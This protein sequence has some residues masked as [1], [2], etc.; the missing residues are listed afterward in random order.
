MELHVLSPDVISRIAAGE[1]VERPASVVKELV[2]NSVD[3]GAG[4]IDIECRGGGAELI[5]VA[6]NGSGIPAPQVETAFLRHATSKI[7]SLDDLV[8]VQTLGFRGEALPSISAVADVEVST[9]PG[10]ADLGTYLYMHGGAIVQ[11]Q[12]KPRARGTTIAVRRL[13]RHFPARLKYLKSQ[14]TENGHSAQVVS[15]YALAYPSIAFSLLLEDRIALRSPGS[16]DLRDVVAQIY[17]TELARAMIHVQSEF[18][19]LT[20]TGLAAPASLSRSGRGHQST[21]VNHRWVRSPLLQRAV[22]EA[23]RGMLQEGRNAIAVINLHMPPDRVDVNVHPS[24]AQ[25]KFADEQDVFRAV[26]DAVKAAL[27]QTS[28]AS[29][30]RHVSLPATGTQG[31]WIVGEADP[32]P[33]YSPDATITTS[34]TEVLPPLRVLGQ[35]LNTYIA[36]EGPDG[37][38]LVDQ[39]AAHERVVYDQLVRKRTGRQAEV[40]SLLDPVTIELTP[41]EDAILGTIQE[42]LSAMGFSI[43]FFGDRTYLLRTVPVVVAD[44]DASAVVRDLLHELTEA[45][46]QGIHDRL[47]IT[48]ACHAAVRAGR[49]LT[50]DEMRH[51]IQ[52]LEGCVQPRTCPH[53]RPT[54]LRFDNVQLEKLFGRRT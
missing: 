15:Q 4:K 37:L 25:V 48:V 20:I 46:R 14:A 38:Y 45:G 17:G 39:H 27:A 8:H 31:T 49:H 19:G 22:D 29:E 33:A 32:V 44:A 26:R 7:S 30:S 43:E 11:H 51:L 50:P 21:F 24:K 16:G 52:Q 23:Y 42:G 47:A 5:C 13:F 35:V 40:Q 9:S 18:N 41:A 3:A 1:V 10:G 54:V 34:G 6:D 2:E 36:A 53:G 28:V 12:N